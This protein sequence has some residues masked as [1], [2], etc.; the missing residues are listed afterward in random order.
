MF[1]CFDSNTG[2]QAR[3]M[4]KAMRKITGS[5]AMSKCTVIFLNQ[6]RSKV[7]VIYGS[8]EVTSGGNALKFFASVRLDTRKKEVLPEN[9]GI[10]IKVKVVKNKVSAPFKVVN[11]DILFGSG[12]DRLGCLVDAALE[13]GVVVRKGSWY[14]FNDL[15]FSQGRLNAVAYL[16]NNKEMTV[17]IEDAVRTACSNGGDTLVKTESDENVSIESFEESVME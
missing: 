6:L 12:I 17:K 9:T 14:S 7:G 1:D 11:L 10:R 8:P 3:L 2:L 4:S 13:L 16:K 5:L 15:N